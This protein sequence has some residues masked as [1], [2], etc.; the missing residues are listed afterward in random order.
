[1]GGSGQCLISNGTGTPPSWQACPAG[2]GGAAT[3]LEC[4]GCVS[5]AELASPK[6]AATH[7]HAGGDITSAVS[8]ATSATTASA[9]AANPTDCGAGQYATTIAA[10]GNLTC[11]QVAYGQVSG[12]PTIPADLSAEPIVTT[13]ASSVLSNERV[14]P[15]C[16]G[17]DK[18][19]FNGTA[20]SCAADQTGAGGSGPTLLRV[21]ADVANSTVNFANVTGL[22]M[23]VDAGTYH[24]DCALTLT[25]AATTTAPQLSINGP[26]ASAIDYSIT[27]ATSATAVHNSAQTAYDTVVNPAT[28]PAAVLL[29]AQLRGS[30]VFT[31]S[32]TF[33]VR[34]RS[35]VAASAATVKRGSTCRVFQ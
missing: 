22:T 29:P 25:S 5:D 32:G 21:S 9:L 33:A 20:I 35:E 14:L 18:L 13:A 16:S 6:A 10:N 4:T 28:G 3:D 12:T 8:A 31:A 17:T 1:M 23:A 15:T 26:T 30:V 11:A 2:S 27:Q 24:F 34:L 19:T 7:T